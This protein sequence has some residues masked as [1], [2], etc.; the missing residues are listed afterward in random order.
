MTW[1]KLLLVAVLCLTSYI[2]GK[3]NV[4]AKW[5]KAELVRTQKLLEQTN[6]AT[7]I[8]H[9]RESVAVEAANL[10][11]TDYQR[12]RGDVAAIASE[13][14]W[15]RNDLE[16][17]RDMSSTTIDACGKRVATLSELYD[18]CEGSYTGMAAKAQGHAIDSLMYQ[19]A[20]PK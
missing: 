13:R 3:A 15:M 17:L 4:R 1:L 8:G 5:D 6:E 20:W 11:K 7:R 14:D 10:A 18:N 2:G 12:L 9:K 16:R 19:K